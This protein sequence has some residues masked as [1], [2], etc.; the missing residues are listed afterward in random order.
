MKRALLLVASAGLAASAAAQASSGAKLDYNRDVRPILSDRC[1]ACHGPD[2]AQRKAGLRL[3]EEAG[4]RATLKSGE[5]AIVPGERGASELV[6]R[7]SSVD[8]DETMPPP[9]FKRQL[10]QAERE[11]LARWVAEG[12]GYQPH[13]AFVAPQAA[14]TPTVRTAGWVRDPLD[15]QVLA[16]LE[17]R[18]LAPE[19][20]ADPVLLLRRASLALTGLPPTPEEADAFRADPSDAAFERAVDALLASPR[21][22]EHM[23]TTWLDLARYADTHGFQTDNPNFVWPWRD[24]LLKALRDNLPY[25]RFVVDLVAGDL[26]PDATLDDRVAT[27]FNRLHRMTE[28]GGSIP[29]EFRQ[30]AI[31]D[32]V[33]V[34]GTAFLGLTLDCARCHDHKYDPVPMRD[35]YALAAMFGSIDENG[36]KPFSLPGDAPPPYVR[37]STP[38]QDARTR[39]LQQKEGDAKAFWSAARA[40]AMAAFSETAAAVAVPAPAGSYSFD[41]LADGLTP[42]AAADGKPASTDR[43][44]PEQLGA[45]AL[46]EGRK[47]NALAFD[48]DGGVWLEGLAGFGRHDS[49]SFAMWIRPGER[50]VRGAI[51]QASGFYTQDADASGIELE[52]D[53]GR[54][55]W[56]AIN[57]WPGSAAS[58][59]TVDA[60]PV[61]RWTHLVAV[62]DGSSSADGLRIYVD[63]SPAPFEVVRDELDGPLGGSTLE[64]GSRS[65][66][67]GFRNGA[68]DE[69][70]VWRAALTAAQA[71]EV[72]RGDGAELAPEPEGLAAAHAADTD[73]AVLAARDAWRAAQRE[74]AAHL[75]PLPRLACMADSARANPTYVLK[76][77]AYD[78]PDRDRPVQPGAI[79]AV[80]PFDAALPK[81]RMGLAR[82]LVD[83]RHPLTARV[84]VNRLWTQVFGRGLVETAENFGVQGAS[85]ANQALLDLLA[86]D[87]VQGDGAWDSRRML[88]RLVL[89]STFRQ[90]SECDDAKLAADPS[91][92]LLSRG[93]ATRLSAEMLRD[94][95]LAASGSLDETFGGPSARPW[96]PEGL[97]HEAGQIGNYVPDM[98]P[99]ARRRSLYSFRK[100][101]VPVPDLAAFDAGTREACTAR[102]GT[103][104]TPLQT[105]VLWNDRVYLDAARATARRAAGE[106]ADVEARV[107]RM[108]RLVCTR[109][110]SSEESAALRELVQTLAARYAAAPQDASKV[111]GRPDADLAALV[112]A[113]TTI[114]ASDGALM[115]R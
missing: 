55:R 79:D 109:A 22:A 69:L 67:V 12:G 84:Q 98:G 78:Q 37:L 41:S 50:N 91:N 31:A 46:G 102:R 25:D 97:W 80:L 27:A 4:S 30:E 64:V 85:P 87:F 92:S 71:R 104:N 52:L 94:Q 93:P 7:V 95:A 29:E 63:G 11:L 108:F 106:A 26:K 39:E 32:R 65:R 24:W 110:P 18:G 20:P 16:A 66:G 43:R 62:Y 14:A 76:R 45:V 36:L 3:D 19:P 21:A 58:V 60:L 1:F 49:V 72:A 28:E 113:C 112:L 13:W 100:R 73:A 34:F 23:A 89:S 114:Y 38:E 107:Q 57:Y 115:V 88:K 105:L 75:D 44:R 40:K 70:R 9:E 5:R 15:A 86:R 81:N 17:A 99:N 96:Q 53:A 82:W 54:V 103:T 42:N 101:T 10:T 2:E 90:R 61:G 35:Y 48:G 74:L 111:C 6:R 59:R 68:L 33:G 47:G 8:P 56:S 83:P 77:G 51:V